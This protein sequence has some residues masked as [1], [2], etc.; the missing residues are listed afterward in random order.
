[1]IQID[2]RIGGVKPRRIL[3]P[4]GSEAK[5]LVR[6]PDEMLKCVVFLGYQLPG[7][8]EVAAGTGFY[9][10][11]LAGKWRFTYLVTAKH[12]IDGIRARGVSEVFI[13]YNLRTGGA[14]WFATPLSSWVSHPD[15]YEVDLAVAPIGIPEGTDHLTFPLESAVTD[16]VIEEQGIG[17][18]DEVFLTGL[19]VHHQG[20]HRNCPIV[21]IG[22][23]AAMP[24]EPI[25]VRAFG[26]MDAYLIEAR[27]IGGISGSPVFVQPGTPQLASEDP[28][29][30]GTGRSKLVLYQRPL[31]LLGLMHGHYVT[32]SDAI[33]LASDDALSRERINVGIAIIV[34]ATKIL[35]TVSQESVRKREE[36]Y[37]AEERAKGL[38]VMDSISEEPN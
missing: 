10:S 32:N 31:Y 22:N 9:V 16:R 30:S 34:P 4:W 5:P 35:E 13:R 23:I 25:E 20:M 15:E 3:H 1:M 28:S 2:A 12:V 8:V 11:R 27:S 36:Q 6:V 24:E 33:D 18:G 19:F 38:L 26:N 7:R 21:R 37:E 14:E 17:I 29:C